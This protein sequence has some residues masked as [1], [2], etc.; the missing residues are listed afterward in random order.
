MGISAFH[1]RLDGDQGFLRGYRNGIVS[2][3]TGKTGEMDENAQSTFTGISDFLGGI[4][5]GLQTVFST[6][7]EAISRRGQ[8]G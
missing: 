8:R 5:T 6:V 1:G 3:F 7:W 4:L 2:F